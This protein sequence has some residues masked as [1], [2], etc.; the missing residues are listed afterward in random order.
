MLYLQINKTNRVNVPRASMNL[1]KMEIS[2]EFPQPSYPTKIFK[3][4]KQSLGEEADNDSSYFIKIKLCSSRLYE[5]NYNA[6]S[7][8]LLIWADVETFY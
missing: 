5:G 3:G 4:R 7:N 8:P 2:Y 6:I 1:D